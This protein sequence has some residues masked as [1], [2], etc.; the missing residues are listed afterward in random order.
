MIKDV[1]KFCDECQSCNLQ[2]TNYQPLA[3]LQKTPVPDAVFSFIS[4]DIVG[5]LNQTSQIINI[6]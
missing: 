1:K 5:P 3:E 2:K 4:L 6:C